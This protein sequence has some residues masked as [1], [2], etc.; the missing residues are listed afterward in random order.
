MKY[1]LTTPC[2][3]C[4]FRKDKPFYLPRA[5]DICEGLLEQDAY[6][7]CHKTMDYEKSSQGKETENTQHCAGALIFLEQQDRPHQMMRIA[8]RLGLYDRTNLNKKIPVYKSTDEMVKGCSMR[9]RRKR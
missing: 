7:S 3:N 2:S 5:R 6:F 1:T 9:P 8:E 4:P